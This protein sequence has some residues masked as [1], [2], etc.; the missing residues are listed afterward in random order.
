METKLLGGLWL[1]ATNMFKMNSCLHGAIL[2][3]MEFGSIWTLIEEC[4]SIDTGAVNKQ[5]CCL[6]YLLVEIYLAYVEK[7]QSNEKLYTEKYINIETDT[8]QVLWL[9]I[10]IK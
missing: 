6:K 3:S 8:R 4:S 7:L 5:H 1:L 10:L 9:I 2:N